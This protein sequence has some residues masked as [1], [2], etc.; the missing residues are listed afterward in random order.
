[1]KALV[2]GASGF[3]GSTLI[4]E[5][6]T[7]GFEVHA[8]MRKTSSDSNLESNGG[9]LKFQRV[10]GDLSDET[11]LRAAV[12][13]VDYIFHLA[14]VTAARNREAYFEFNAE[15]TERLARVT[16]EERPQLQRFVYVSSLAAAGPARGLEPLIENDEPR[17][18]SLYG[19]SKLEGERALLRYKSVYPI[20]II[21]PPMVYG[22]RDK[23]VFTMIQSVARNLMPILGAS[24]GDEKYYSLIH[25][26]DLCRGIVQSAVAQPSKVPSGEIFYLANSRY[27][28]YREIMGVI[29]ETLGRD[30]LR[31]R[32]P[33]LAV[34]AIATVL[35]GAG[36]LLRRNFSLNL[37]KL[38]ELNPDYWICSSQKARDLLG[39][40]PEYDLSTGMANAIEWYRKH[41]WI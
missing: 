29:A 1:M 36:W 18:V 27:H 6:G 13:N 30:P 33:R 32:V 22:P 11:S 25:V 28:T 4:E 8:M 20:S 31:I 5:L 34:T 12:K 38:N 37:D 26:R 15:G 14:G 7:L 9:K 23:G 3:I 39:F 40:E 19:K 17:P 16:A 10:E 21:R 41:E 24:E 2:T 35:S